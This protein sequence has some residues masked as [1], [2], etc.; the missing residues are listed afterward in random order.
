MVV[1][2][3]GGF[4]ILGAIPILLA[5]DKPETF[6]LVNYSPKSQ[7]LLRES[8]KDDYPEGL[9]PE[10]DR[11][12]G[13]FTVGRHGV[14]LL[15]EAY[16]HIWKSL[17]IDTIIG[18]DGGVDSLMRGDEHNAGTVLE[19]FIALAALDGIE[20]KKILACVGFGS[21]TEEELNHFRVLENIAALAKDGHFLGTCSLTKEMADFQQY[22]WV[23]KHIME[24]GRKSHIQT[25]IIS[26][27]HG[28]FGDYHMYEEID[29][30]VWEASKSPYFISPLT[31]MYW[32]FKMDGVI[33]SNLVI[34]HLKPSNT[35]TDA[36]TLFRN[37]RKS[38]RSR[39]T[40]P[41]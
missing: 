27:V 26:A 28:E 36:M 35:F 7:F 1:G 33:K 41:L 40:I 3:G 37:N 5:L 17:D 13:V 4:D 9:I 24:Q 10:L 21:E 6:A 11:V 38:L 8:T 34:E 25:K 15:H 39:E 19:D 29:A 23:C 16:R 31:G 20:C 30:R 12:E 2:I 32:F 22:E 14:K 18:I